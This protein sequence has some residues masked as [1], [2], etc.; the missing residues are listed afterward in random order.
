ML[1][2]SSLLIKGFQDVI[3]NSIRVHG[4]MLEEIRELIYTI[5]EFR[6]VVEAGEENSLVFWCFLESIRV[7]GHSLYLCYVGL[8]RNVYDNLR[9]ALESIVQAYYIDSNHASANLSTKLEILKEIEDKREYHAGRLIEEKIA[10]KS[11]DCEGL[12]CKGLL[13]KEYANLSRIVHPSHEKVMD[14]VKDVLGEKDWLPVAIDG[15]EISRIFELMKQTFDILFFF[16]IASF[17][18]WKNTLRK[19]TKLTENIQKYNL[20]LLKRALGS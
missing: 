15:E 4:K 18:K 9:H 5:D 17:P 8:Y 16:V 2:E 10:F 13:R 6:S 12:D 11:L 14:T 7:A 20:N 1:K 3:E 19:N